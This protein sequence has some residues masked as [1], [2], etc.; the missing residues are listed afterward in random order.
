MLTYTPSMV[1]RHSPSRA[2]LAGSLRPDGHYS[3]QQLSWASAAGTTVLSGP[4][5]LGPPGCLEVL[6]SVTPMGGGS[7]PLD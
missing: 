5:P 6:L 3:S 1:S 7:G 2:A 4:A